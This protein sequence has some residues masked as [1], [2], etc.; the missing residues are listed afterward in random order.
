MD[1]RMMMS[2]DTKA[3]F[4]SLGDSPDSRAIKKEYLEAAN[5]LNRGPSE[6]F[7]IAC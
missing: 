1:D 7:L 4:N 3:L 2:P 5:K 6:P